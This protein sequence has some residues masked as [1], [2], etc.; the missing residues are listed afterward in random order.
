VKV[1]LPTA[2][3]EL[4]QS[5][6]IPNAVARCEHARSGTTALADVQ[7]PASDA[8]IEKEALELLH[9]NGNTARGGWIIADQQDL[10]LT[11]SHRQPAFDC[12]LPRLCWTG[13]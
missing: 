11:F 8:P 2:S 6:G 10:H 3:R 13:K 12:L 9:V 5:V 1:G 4:Q 7:D